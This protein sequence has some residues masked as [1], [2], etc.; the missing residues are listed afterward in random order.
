MKKFL[1]GVIACCAAMSAQA[2][3]NSWY[4]KFGYTATEPDAGHLEQQ[5]A[6]ELGVDKEFSFARGLSLAL[7]YQFNP[8]IAIEGGFIDWGDSTIGEG[9]YYGDLAVD[10]IAGHY[11]SKA[12]VSGNTSNL[13]V[14]LSTSVERPFSVGIKGGVHM[15]TIDERVTTVDEWD[16]VVGEDASGDLL[17]TSYYQQLVDYSRS[18]DGSDPYAGLIASYRED[19]WALS[20]EYTV[21]QTEFADPS[22]TI[23]S[24]SKE[25]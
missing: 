2:L 23:F 16:Q 3:E 11:R 17:V 4:L 13:G 9:F 12:K 14:V 22:S 25:F 6:E 5:L 20:V 19:G 24:V 15:W 8:Y 1:F 21:F 10:G 18:T 7:G